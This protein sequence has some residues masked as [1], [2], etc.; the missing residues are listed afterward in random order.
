VRDGDGYFTIVDRKKDMIVS[1]GFQRLPA[2]DRRRA[3]GSPQCV[4]GGRDRRA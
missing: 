3:V 2:R 4:R 1:G